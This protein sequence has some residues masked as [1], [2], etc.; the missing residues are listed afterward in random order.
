MI[1]RDRFE[2]IMDA[3]ASGTAISNARNRFELICSAIAEAIGNAGGGGGTTVIRD[4][5]GTYDSPSTQYDYIETTK[6]MSDYD[7]LEITFKWSGQ[8]ASAPVDA[9]QIVNVPYVE[10][11]C[12]Q[13]SIP[14]TSA[15][16]GILPVRWE[17]TNSKKLTKIFG[18]NNVLW[19]SKIVG[20]KYTDGE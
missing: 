12:G 7:Y 3:I 18:P 5:I 11:S 4:V 16:T 15:N 20:V 17:Y 2:K 8:W 13:T 14:T 19:I 1:T 10:G 9:Y 6:D